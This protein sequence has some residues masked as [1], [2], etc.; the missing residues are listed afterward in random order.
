MG[1]FGT[2]KNKKPS[3]D[4]KE[5]DEIELPKLPSL[6]DIPEGKKPKPI[7][8]EPLKNPSLPSFPGSL[9]GEKMNQN[10][11]KDAV[12]RHEGKDVK[13]EI[14]VMHTK[15]TAKS[16][17]TPS[18]MNLP[19]VPTPKKIQGRSRPRSLEI[20]DFSPPRVEQGKIS[21]A[22]PLFIKLDTFEKAISNFNEI[23]LRIREVETLLGNIRELK[24]QEE[25]ELSDWE[26]EIETI[27]ARLEQIDNEIFERMQ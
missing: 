9:L 12:T 25:R 8:E 24:N 4:N 11:I 1:F 13:T 21:G 3:K 23:K 18:I 19:P 16:R 6:P 14:P 27:K 5:G 7:T 26:D 20:S 17:M 22:E 10:T 2:N 15:G